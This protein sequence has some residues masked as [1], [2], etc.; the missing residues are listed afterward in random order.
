VGDN[1]KGS[2]ISLKRAEEDGT[3]DCGYAAADACARTESEYIF[4]RSV[5]LGERRKM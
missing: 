5:V 1:G 4:S 3:D 2:K